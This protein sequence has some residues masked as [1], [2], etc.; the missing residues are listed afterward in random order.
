[1]ASLG[2]IYAALSTVYELIKIIKDIFD[3]MDITEKDIENALKDLKEAV[4][5]SLVDTLEKVVNGLMAA[6]KQLIEAFQSL[7]DGM[8]ENIKN[9]EK[10]DKE[11]ADLLKSALE[12]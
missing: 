4:E 9:I 10:T 5:G 3:E 6:S 11:G 1:M 8:E 12:M 2:E 7:F